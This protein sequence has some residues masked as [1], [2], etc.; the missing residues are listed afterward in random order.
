M[1]GVQCCGRLV[2]SLFVIVFQSFVGG[3]GLGLGCWVV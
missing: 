3:V 2:V 1:A